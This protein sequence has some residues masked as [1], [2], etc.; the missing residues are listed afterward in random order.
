MRLN[1][2]QT[3]GSVV[4][5]YDRQRITPPVFLL[6][7]CASDDIIGPSNKCEVD[8]KKIVS[9]ILSVLAVFG[10]AACAVSCNDDGLTTGTREDTADPPPVTGDEI[11]D[12]AASG[13]DEPQGGGIYKISSGINYESVTVKADEFNRVT[14]VYS[15]D[16]PVSAE[17]AYLSGGDE[18]TDVFYLEK[19]QKKAFCGLLT[20]SFDGVR[21]SGISRVTV[22]PLKEGVC[23]FGLMSVS[24][25]LVSIPETDSDGNFCI[26][27]TRYK[28]GIRLDWGGAISCI[29]DK[30]AGIDGLSNL[31]NQ[32]D[33]GRLVQQSYYGTG[34][35]EGVY[36]PGKF[37]DTVWN[38]NPVQGGDVYGTHSKIVDFSVNGNSIY[39]RTMPKDWANDGLFLPCYMENTYT[40]YE[41]RITVDNRF[42]D[43]SGFTHP[44]FLQEL[45]AFYTV[46]FLETLVFYNGKEPW[47]DGG[48]TVKSDVTDW[49]S[50]ENT[51][52]NVFNMLRGNTETWAA[53]VNLENDFGIG[54]YT[55]NTEVLNAGRYKYDG[56]K[57]STAD[58]TNY[59]ALRSDVKLTSYEELNY[60]YMIA[61]GSV[62]GI[63]SVFRSNRDFADNKSLDGAKKEREGTDKLYDLSYVDFTE[64]GTEDLFVE[65]HN[66]EA[67]YDEKEGCVRLSAA[68]G[69][70]VYCALSFADNAETEL[71]AE[72]YPSFQIEYMLPAGNSGKAVSSEFFLSAGDVTGAMPGNS[73]SS[74]LISDGKFHKLTLR[75]DSKAVWSGVI[76]QIR[77]DYFNDC[78]TGDTMYIRSFRLIPGGG[79]LSYED[80]D[81]SREE[82][83]SAVA[84]AVR[85]AANYDVKEQALKITVSDGLDVN[86]SIDY[87]KSAPALDMGDYKEYEIEYMIPEENKDLVYM[88]EL[89][90]CVGD[91]TGP[92][93]ENCVR[94]GLVKDGKYH[95]LAV[96]MDEFGTH[97]GV[98]HALRFD[99]F[100]TCRAG[101]IL[102]I[103]GLKLLKK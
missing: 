28:F 12:F 87:G 8:M 94:K 100:A 40:L 42:F 81:F 69:F 47:T 35:I 55:P 6:T 9:L 57:S 53:W 11:P 30:T 2:E 89:Y 97:T 102:Y 61:S 82:N 50:K 46:S 58:P 71:H 1:N 80:I 63:R 5:I 31:I 38:Y 26:E 29:C 16:A 18:K 75:T 20:G 68:E 76:N 84:G 62:D 72:D 79:D 103:K 10:A 34:P 92:T 17:V 85:A 77:F 13:Y 32:H 25:D 98:I 66:T 3:D 93:E 59:I 4:R 90:F 14:L 56:S 86:V 48:L 37:L 27:N 43:F 44:Y 23:S 24:A 78:E 74:G 73:V 36:D 96:P 45:P 101:D 64:K 67:V 15:S 19:G 95:R 52:Q 99:F 88:C 60:S 70:D 91:V 65:R 21:A 22:K 49:T 33:T 7:I 41:D 51:G 83:A 54:V 39:V